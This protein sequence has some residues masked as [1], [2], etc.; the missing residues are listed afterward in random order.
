MQSNR[1]RQSSEKGFALVTA[2]MAC[3]ILFALAMLIIQLST[4]DLKVSSRNVGDKK[5]LSAAETGIHR[6][7]QEINMLPEVNRSTLAAVQVTNAQVN[8]AADTA[9]R[10]T[11]SNVGA[12][13]PGAA[14]R[15]R[16]GFAIAGG[17]GWVDQR[18]MGR[19]MG[20]NTNYN[21]KVTIDVGMAYFGPGG[22]TMSR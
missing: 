7:I 3:A 9:S 6:M 5:A 15:P 13:T 20:E 21:S 19:T 16:A 22:D 14:V 18:F 2:L 17:Q 12:P 4:G 11:I 10:Y 1:K 8:A